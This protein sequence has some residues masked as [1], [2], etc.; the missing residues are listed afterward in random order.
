MTNIQSNHIPE[1]KIMCKH[2]G[3]IKMLSA[4]YIQNIFKLLKEREKKQKKKVVIAKYY[5]ILIVENIIII[6][7]I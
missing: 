2:K 1:K 3:P 7:T 5:N 4:G 6:F